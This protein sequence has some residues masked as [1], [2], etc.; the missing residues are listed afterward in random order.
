MGHGSLR[1]ACFAD[2]SL[3]AP[4]RSGW[5]RIEGFS[6]RAVVMALVRKNMDR[7]SRSWSLTSR[8]Q[9]GQVDT[10]HSDSVLRLC[11]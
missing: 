11:N 9:S 6:T 8:M 7:R 4:Y 2:S 5:C 10:L 3:E 1:P